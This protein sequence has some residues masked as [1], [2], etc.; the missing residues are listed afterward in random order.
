[1]LLHCQSRLAWL[2]RLGL[3]YKQKPDAELPV[4]TSKRPYKCLTLFLRQF[5]GFEY[6]STLFPSCWSGGI[7][8]MSEFLGTQFLFSI[9]QH[10]TLFLPA[11]TT[12]R[13]L[14]QLHP[15]LPKLIEGHHLNP[16]WRHVAETLHLEAVQ[17]LLDPSFSRS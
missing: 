4:A 15:Q 9:I 5:C 3:P 13:T 17:P 10:R 16:T 1:M 7:F 6:I 11:K 2:A 14:Y 8:A 12:F